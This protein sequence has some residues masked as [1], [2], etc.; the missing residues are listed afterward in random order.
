MIVKDDANANNFC[1]RMAMEMW[2]DYQRFL[3]K[4]NLGEDFHL[5]DTDE[6]PEEEKDIDQFYG[7]EDDGDEDVL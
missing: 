1:D 6:D 7:S 3:Q 2:E 4:C 5:L